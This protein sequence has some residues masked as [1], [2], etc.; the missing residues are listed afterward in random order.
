MG[1]KITVTVNQDKTATVDMGTPA[2]AP[3]AIPFLAE[4]EESSYML[5]LTDES[6]EFSVVNVGNPHATL[7]VPNV[8][9]ADVKRLG[10]IL[11]SHERFQEGINVGF[12][13]IV[14]SNHLKLRVFER[15]AGE[16]LACGTGACAAAVLAIKN[17]QLQSPVQVDLNGGRLTI[18]WQ[19]ED[20]P[21]FMSGPCE[22]VF[23]G[24]IAA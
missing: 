4:S 22:F 11:A 2:F 1:G 14:D 15:G 19:G 24:E 17:H 8:D 3:E 9:E 18:H 23:H 12:M 20:N 21:I 10:A 6:V 7:T 16:T 13:Q 5:D